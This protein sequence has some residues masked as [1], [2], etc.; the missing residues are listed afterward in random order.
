MRRN[1]TGL[2]Y[3][4]YIEYNRPVMLWGTSHVKTY[5]LKLNKT[6]FATVRCKVSYVPTLWTTEHPFFNYMELILIMHMLPS[7]RL[8]DYE[9]TSAPAALLAWEDH[10]GDRVYL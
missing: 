10:R 9:A 6:L 5:S 8:Y 3:S 2:I 1:K 4:P 7:K